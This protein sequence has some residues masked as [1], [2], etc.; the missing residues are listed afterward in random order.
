MSEAEAGPRVIGRARVE[1]EPSGVSRQVLES[2]ND[3]VGTKVDL[4]NHSAGRLKVVRKVYERAIRD[5][6]H[7]ANCCSRSLWIAGSWIV[8]RWKLKGRVNIEV[9]EKAR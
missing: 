8:E 7:T 3:C 6:P 9:C 5:A 4:R 2:G 1:K